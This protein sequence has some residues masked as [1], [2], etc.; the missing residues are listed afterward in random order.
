MNSSPCRL[1][2]L[3]ILLCETYI[4]IPL[5]FEI[6]LSFLFELRDHNARVKLVKV[7][8]TWRSALILTIPSSTCMRAI[9]NLIRC[10]WS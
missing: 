9:L 6:S 1:L 10:Y 3:S 2:S 5:G 7:N 8:W 4:Y